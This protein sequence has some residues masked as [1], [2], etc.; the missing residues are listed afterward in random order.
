MSATEVHLTVGGEEAGHAEKQEIDLIDRDPNHMNDH[1]KITFEEIFAEPHPTI[2]AFDPVWTTSYKVF[3][4]TKLW[5]YRITTAIFA[6]PL[7]VIWGIWFALMACGHIWCCVPTIKTY[8]ICCGCFKGFWM[9]Y[10]DCCLRPLYEAAG[11]LF[12]NI[13]VRVIKGDS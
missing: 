2:F 11:Y 12:Y 1:L 6:V 4:N 7:S 13:R 9:A 8:E 5:C 3:R 10:L